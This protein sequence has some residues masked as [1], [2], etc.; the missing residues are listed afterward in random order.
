MVSD[1]HS[2]IVAAAKAAFEDKGYRVSMTDI[3]KRA[4]VAKQTLYNHFASKEAL[5]ATVITDCG[6]SVLATLAQD[7][8]SMKDK[9]IQFSYALRQLAM[10]AHGVSSYRAMT[11]EAHQFPELAASFYAQGVGV[12]HQKLQDV[13]Q[14]ATESGSLAC[15]DVVLAA[16]ML[17]S[18]LTGFERSRLLLGVALPT[19]GTDA[20]VRAIVE[21]FMRAFAPNKKG[22]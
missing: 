1:K 16:D 5:F 14:Q 7:G 3:A 21:A 19:D 22:E 17:L 10:T 2:Q 4:G 8:L 6:A 12:T 11:A 15:P 20:K 9:L 13:L 18:M